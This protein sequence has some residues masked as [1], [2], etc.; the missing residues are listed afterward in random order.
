MLKRV[1]ESQSEDNNISKKLNKI[2]QD[3][4]ILSAPSNSQLKKQLTPVQQ[5]KKSK[6][7]VRSVATSSKFVS[8]LENNLENKKLSQKKRIK[9]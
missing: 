7:C 9:Q 5:I 8:P 2:E 6:P 4:S 1:I 3:K